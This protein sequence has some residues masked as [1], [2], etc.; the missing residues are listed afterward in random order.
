MARLAAQLREQQ[1]EAA[2]LEQAIARN[3]EGWLWRVSGEQ[4]TLA[5]IARIHKWEKTAKNCQGA[6]RGLFS[7]G[8]SGGGGP[9]RLHRPRP[10]RG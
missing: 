3:L 2:K 10:F 7:P 5:A 4:T 9:S 8:M 6:N 1:A